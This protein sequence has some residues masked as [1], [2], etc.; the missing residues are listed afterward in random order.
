MKFVLEAATLE[1]RGKL[2]VGGK[3]TFLIAAGEKEIRRVPRIG[4]SCQNK[5]IVLPPMITSPRTK[6]S[7]MGPVLPNSLE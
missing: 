6:N 2:L 1:Q 5:R 3:Q 7:R 4:S